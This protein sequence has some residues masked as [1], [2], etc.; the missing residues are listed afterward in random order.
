MDVTLPP[1]VVRNIRS[2]VLIGARAPGIDVGIDAAGRSVAFLSAE[3][4]NAGHARGRVVV[5]GPD[6]RAFYALAVGSAVAALAPYAAALAELGPASPAV[7]AVPV[8]GAADY[9]PPGVVSIHPGP[10]GWP[11]DAAA[12]VAACPFARDGY[13]VADVAVDAWIRHGWR[14]RRF[15]HRVT[16]ADWRALAALFGTDH[17]IPIANGYSAACSFA[18]R[19]MLTAWDR[20]YVV[21]SIYR[22]EDYPPPPHGDDS[23]PAGS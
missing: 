12:Y 13:G 22:R 8:V 1:A 19:A 10:G 20:G 15:P 2:A 14:V 21:R 18:V 16:R 11:G 7:R 4:D 5:L 9:T 23:A 17:A 3:Y 6:D